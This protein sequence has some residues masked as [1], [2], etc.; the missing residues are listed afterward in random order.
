MEQHLEPAEG[1]IT[2]PFDAIKHTS[3]EGA[4]YWS[5]RE[6]MPLMGYGKWQSFEVPLKRAM[7]SAEN[8][9]QTSAFTRSRK[10][11]QAGDGSTERVDFHLTRFAAYLVAMNGDPNKPK[12]AAAQAYF[13][14]R[15]REAEVTEQRLALPQ[16]YAEALRELATTYEQKTALETQNTALENEN[17][18][19][20]GGDGITIRQFIKTY[21]TAPNER[22]F[23]EWFYYH[24]YLI[25]GRQYNDDGTSARSGSG[26]KTRWDHQ[27][28]TYIGREYFK[29]V[30][31]G[32]KK[33]GGAR[34]KVIP[35][36]AL[37]L[38]QLL[39]KAKDLPTQMTKNGQTALDQ[40]TNPGQLHV[41]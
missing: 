35:E 37:N 19:L 26:P 34:A 31:T 7:K 39:L 11:V 1:V 10:R 4:E 41:V 17:R 40:Y 18:A 3:P 14:T 12:V 15:T 20:T 27:H 23:F 9:G 30:P 32:T 38:V 6:L 16:T 2:S 22:A 33:Y 25:D 29:L 13:A 8:Q 24:G 36:K 21:F 28:P 5:A